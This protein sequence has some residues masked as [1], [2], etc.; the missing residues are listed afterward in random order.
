[1][2]NDPVNQVQIELPENIAQGVYA[3]L[4]IITHSSSEFVIDFIRML[5]GITSPKVKSRLILTPEYAKRL[6][7]ALD[8]N[9]SSYEEL[10][11]YID[12]N[13]EDPESFISGGDA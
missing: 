5:P 4:T 1:M 3:N 9:I 10:H 11:G 7:M 13:M 6:L 8:E 12:L 2:E